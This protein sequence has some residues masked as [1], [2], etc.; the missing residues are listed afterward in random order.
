MAA[1]IPLVPTHP[2][3]PYAATTQ[4]MRRTYPLIANIPFSVGRNPQGEYQSEVFMPWGQ[5]NPTPGEF[6]IELRHF[7][8]RPQTEEDLRRTLTGEMFHYLGAKNPQGERVNPQWYALK[9]RVIQ[10]MSPRDFENAQ[11]NWI[12]AKKTAGETR[13]FD[14]WMDESAIDQFI[15]GTMFPPSTEQEWVDRARDLPRYAPLQS[16]T[17]E[18]MRQLLT[19]GK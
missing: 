3:D 17:I 1:G 13:S 14:Q 8:D 2:V 16:Q 5:D 12:N 18:R 19:T 11:R 7:L 9:Q 6:H 10:T 15:G 4:W